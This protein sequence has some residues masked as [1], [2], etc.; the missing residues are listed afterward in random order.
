MN[1]IAP[2][3]STLYQEMHRGVSLVHIVQ[4]IQYAYLIGFAETDGLVLVAIL[5]S[6]RGWGAMLCRRTT[7]E[8]SHTRRRS[9]LGQ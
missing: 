8:V 7:P 5:R 4:T 1:K 2:M 3:T 9:A 6:F